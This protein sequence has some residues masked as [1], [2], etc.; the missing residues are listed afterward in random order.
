MSQYTLKDLFPDRSPE[1]LKEAEENL[2]RYLRVVVRIY[3]Y[4]RSD[5]ERYMEFKAL[6]E[7]LRKFRIDADRSNITKISYNSEA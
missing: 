5:P 3:D 7:K 6:T 4:I 2:R 1:E